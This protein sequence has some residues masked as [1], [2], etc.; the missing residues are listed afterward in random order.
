M[1]MDAMKNPVPLDGPVASASPAGSEERSDERP[2]GEAAAL[3]I[4]DPETPEKPQSR[5]ASAHYNLDILEKA[6]AAQTP[7]EVV[8][9]VRRAG[10]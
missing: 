1:M 6:K 5:R 8:R 10:L 3:S 9:R 7:A 4:P 2:A